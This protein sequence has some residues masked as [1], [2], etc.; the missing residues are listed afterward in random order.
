[1][2]DNIDDLDLKI[3]L[4]LQENGRATITELAEKVGSSRPTV[5]NRLKRLIDKGI[6]IVTGGVNM[7][8]FGYKMACIGLEVKSSETRAEFEEGLT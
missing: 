6:V 1:M 8:K 5:T 7:S 3:V 2:S 4:Q